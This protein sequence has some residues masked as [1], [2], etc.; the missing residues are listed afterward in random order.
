MSRISYPWKGGFVDYGTPEWD[1]MKAEKAANAK[2]RKE[3][4][5][6]MRDAE[7]WVTVHGVHVDPYGWHKGS[8]RTAEM[9]KRA[10][11]RGTPLPTFSIGPAN[12]GSI[13]G[14]PYEEKD[15]AAPEAMSI[16]DR[17]TAVEQRLDE[18]ED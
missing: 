13:A 9:Y 5:Q 14:I 16:I 15:N 1:A 6:A 2:R 11:E 17:I 12:Y 8:P 10:Y 4:A 18:L 7:G 3:K